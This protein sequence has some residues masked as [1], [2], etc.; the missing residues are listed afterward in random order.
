MKYFEKA[1]ITILYCESVSTLCLDSGHRP[2]L[3]NNK[4]N[5]LPVR[6]DMILEDSQVQLFEQ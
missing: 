2:S 3:Y 4:D 5:N 6:H 1:H